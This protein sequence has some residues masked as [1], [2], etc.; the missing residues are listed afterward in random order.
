MRMFK[1]NLLMISIITN[2][3]DGAKENFVWQILIL[4]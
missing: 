2:P 4:Q 1:L 3:F